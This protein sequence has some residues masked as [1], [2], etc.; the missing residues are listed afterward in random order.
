MSNAL[1][2][3]NEERSRLFTL[4]RRNNQQ[5]GLTAAESAELVELSKRLPIRRWPP[6]IRQP[7]EPP[8]TI[9]IGEPKA[10]DQIASDPGVPDAPV[11]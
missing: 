1:P 7:N 11:V 4:D 3:T 2:L 8:P 5:A 6:P 9:I 10:I